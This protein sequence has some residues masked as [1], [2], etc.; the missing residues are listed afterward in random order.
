MKKITLFIAAAFA[1]ASCS[2]IAFDEQP[3]NLEGNTALEN[4]TL[5]E[6]FGND[7][8]L[9]VATG[10][11]DASTRIS[12]D[13]QGDVWNTTWDENDVI[14]AFFAPGIDQSFTEYGYYQMTEYGAEVSTFTG[15]AC[16]EGYV[17]R[18][19]AYPDYYAG[20]AY[21]SGKLC[22]YVDL[23]SQV[24]GLK[25]TYMIDGELLDA[26]SETAIP[27]MYHIGAAADLSLHFKNVGSREYTITSVELLNAPATIYVN[28]AEAIDS[29]NLCAYTTYSSMIIDVEDRKISEY[30]SE[31]DEV[32]IKF[33]INPM[34]IAAGSS[35]TFRISLNDESGNEYCY[36]AEIE[37]T[38]G[39]AVNF[40]R[41][42]YNTIRAT[43][44]MDNVVAN[45]TD[46]TLADLSATNI[47]ET[48]AWT[49]TDTTA[50]T[51]DF[52]G[53]S[54]AIAALSGTTRK[55]KVN[56]PNL[57]AIPAYAMF[58][59]ELESTT[60]AS[61]A[62]YSVT[63]DA[64]KSV[65]DYAFY[66]ASALS[67]ASFASATSTGVSVFECCYLLS[68]V[69]LPSVVT[70]GDYTLASCT[71]LS[72][73]DLPE[74]L[75][76]GEYGCYFCSAMT[77]LSMPK[78][79][80]V[81]QSGFAYTTSL[82]SVDAPEVVEIQ[83]YGFQQSALTSLNM[84][85][86]TSTGTYTF[87]HCEFET[88]ELPSLKSMGTYT[89]SNC[90]TLISVYLPVVESIT[91]GSLCNCDALV[92][93][94]APTATYIAEGACLDDGALVNLNVPMSTYIG[95]TAFRF[96]TSL[97]DLYFPYVEEV[98]NNAFYSCTSLKSIYMP[99]ASV[100][101]S[102]A[103]IYITTVESFEVATAPGVMITQ[104]GQS[105]SI[106]YSGSVANMVFTIGSLNAGYVVDDLYFN[107]PQYNGRTTKMG[108][109]KEIV[110]VDNEVED[111]SGV[112][113]F[114]EGSEI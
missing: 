4:G 49:I 40:E 113:D 14:A 70:L 84:P 78:A 80:V 13:S 92:T 82:E 87:S 99:S 79:T 81:S 59:T 105:N 53:F 25:R 45:Y 110:I 17:R 29:E 31:E 37:N 96:C 74:V 7:F 39:S 15:A 72:K 8:S 38:T 21:V 63:A 56:F 30:N 16:E 90:D 97:Q 102:Y 98:G 9:K 67:S 3:L 35:L 108:P 94:D 50:T 62:L 48:D 41:S 10:N 57:E 26:T 5:T 95:N 55:I 1:M 114:G 111:E 101:D 46:I 32:S 18:L 34:S 71:S 69:N 68:T 91:S 23:T 2:E 76:I 65:G 93:I 64:A 6:I 61:S 47:P 112:E 104:F 12:V 86:L 24:E 103:F 89:F 52:A 100:F 75:T 60:Y 44:D 36:T 54:E 73:L 66:W 27:T 20:F 33:N 77:E 43:C 22:A 107:A 28:L 58:G 42:T 11:S 83:D 51:A 85:K 106:F 109:F 19:V 88:V